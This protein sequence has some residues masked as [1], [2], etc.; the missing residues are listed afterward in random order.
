MK[1]FRS[2][3]NR[4]SRLARRDVTSRRR[5]ELRRLAADVIDVDYAMFLDDKKSLHN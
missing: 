2:G 3:N 1:T 5:L 4:I